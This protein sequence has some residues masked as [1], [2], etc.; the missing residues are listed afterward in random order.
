MKRSKILTSAIVLLLIA[1]LTF[2]LTACEENGEGDI[3]EPPPPLMPGEEVSIEMNAQG[4]DDAQLISLIDSGEIPANVTHLRLSENE[5]TDAT[6]LAGLTELRLL[7]VGGN[8][9][10]D[11]TQLAELTNLTNLDL[12]RNGIS[13]ISALSGLTNLTWLRLQNNSISDASPLSGLTNLEWADL[14]LNHITDWS[15]V[16]HVEYVQGR[17]D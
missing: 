7:D 11:L 6:P 5:L 13:D 1:A 3:V 10:T 4:I 17:P 14:F 15:P 16:D 9:I 2:A 12:W 8:A